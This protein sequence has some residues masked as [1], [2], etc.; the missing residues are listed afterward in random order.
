MQENI[1][2]MSRH[3]SARGTPRRE[4]PGGSL[5]AQHPL[6]EQLEASQITWQ[7]L[8]D[9]DSPSAA[10]AN[11]ASACESA[12]QSATSSASLNDLDKPV[13]TQTCFEA[14]TW[15]QSP[16]G[17]EGSAAMTSGGDEAG[18]WR[19]GTD[20]AVQITPVQTAKFSKPAASGS[21][22]AEVRGLCPDAHLQEQVQGMQQQPADDDAQHRSNVESPQEL[23]GSGLVVRA[24]NFQ[25]GSASGTGAPAERCSNCCVLEAR[26]QDLQAQVRSW[27]M[28]QETAALW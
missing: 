12:S 11:P 21:M 9:V 2:R 25:E 27:P 16:G 5:P 1:N 14:Q 13:A 17:N 20:C 8:N 10:E 4:P 7:L 22:T 23:V 26:L 19:A 28:P 6:S 3:G 24:L 18:M 15:Q